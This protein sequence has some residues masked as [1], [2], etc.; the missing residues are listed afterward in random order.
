MSAAISKPDRWIGL[1]SGKLGIYQWEV[2]AKRKA[3]GG[4][5]AGARRPCIL[6]GTTWKVG[7]YNF[8]RS[9]YRACAGLKGH[10][11]ATD[12]PLV[13]TGVQPSTGTS[14]D[15]TAVGMIFAPAVHH[16]RVVLSGGRTQTLRLHRFSRR[17]ARSARL[18]RFEYAAFARR[19]LWCAERMVALSASDKTLWD[20]GTDEFGCGAGGSGTRFE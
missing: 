1:D 16:V 3:R 18:G 19:G 2:K 17:Q 15:M 9:R 5:R 14:V 7:P 4:G 10:L 20:S 8:R 11:T 13:A 6:V 12:P